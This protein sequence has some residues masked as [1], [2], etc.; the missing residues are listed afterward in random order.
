MRRKKNAG[1]RIKVIGIIIPIVLVIIVS[2]F[3]LARNMV[4]KSSKEKLQVESQMYTEQISS[5]TSQI[6]SELQVY[7]NGI[8]SGIFEDDDEILS[9]LETTCE[10]SEAYP[11]GLYMGDDNGVYLDGSGWVPGDDW[12]LTEREWYV[13]GKEKEAFEFGEPY[14]DSMTG[15][16]C[17]SASVRVDYS[18]A[19]RVLATDV[20]L[21]YVVGLVNDIVN[22]SDFEAFLVTKESQMIIA[23]PDTDMLAQTLDAEG[24]DALYG[25]IATALSEEKDGIVTVKGDKEEY[26]ACI[27]PI[28]NTDWYLV[29]YV[30][31]SKVLADLHQMEMIMAAIAIVAALILIVAV[32]RAMNHVVKPVEKV[33]N[34]I[35]K[36][37]EGDFTQNLEIKGNDEIAKM[38]NNMQ[39][40]ITQMR[41][42]IS[43]IS[44]T[45]NWLNKQS[46]DN[47]KVSE[48]LKDASSNQYRAME[49]MDE[50]VEKLTMAV[51]DVSDQME[52]MVELIH[53][54]RTD[55][56]AADELMKESVVMSQNGKSDMENIDGGMSNINTSITTLS[57]QIGKVGDATDQIGNMVNVIMEIAEETNLLS[58]NASIEAARAGEAGRGF[59][60]VAEQI[61]KL[62]ANSSIAADDISKLTLEI[63]ETVQRAV[64]QMSDSVNEVQ[65]NLGIVS[66]ARET[67][68]ILYEKVEETSQRVAKMIAAVGQVDAVANQMEQ[69]TVD[70]VH[71]TE[72]IAQSARDL[73]QHTKNVVADSNIVADSAEELKKESMELIERMSGFRI[74]N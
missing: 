62:A 48:S 18:K 58:L 46:V 23:H 50:M 29:T 56:Q 55:G 24:L 49:I 66:D 57:Q 44:N 25:D 38:S 40:F 1:I 47:E 7:Q 14:Y 26:L 37:A 16:V 34:I 72:Q 39:G 3:V 31:E 33:T 68:D 74:E 63:Q 53:T 27:N 11:S 71:A 52:K 22:Q 5:W 32:L 19:I 4:L 6:F 10:E 54:T 12:V 17:V 35:G 15:Q 70:Q 67:F 41:S 21:D 28:E 9:Y 64:T 43:E 69:I 73:D 30:T 65:K 51:E 42:T 45:A 60:V 8:E 36:I 20:Y 59:A 2:F 13:E 61:G